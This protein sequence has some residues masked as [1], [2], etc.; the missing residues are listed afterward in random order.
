MPPSKGVFAEQR[1]NAGKDRFYDGLIHHRFKEANFDVLPTAAGIWLANFSRS[2]Q[3]LAFHRWTN[4]PR[5]VYRSRHGSQC[6][7]HRVR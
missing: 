2:I 3:P 4:K 6:I 5:S 7:Y 1:K